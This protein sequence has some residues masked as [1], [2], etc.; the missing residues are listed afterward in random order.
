M[1]EGSGKGVR[2]SGE[3]E[4]EREAEGANKVEAAP[5]LSLRSLERFRAAHDWFDPR[6]PEATCATPVGK[7]ENPE[8]EYCVH[9]VIV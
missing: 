1:G 4:R 3:E 5:G 7:P 8:R 6:T 9:D 2:K